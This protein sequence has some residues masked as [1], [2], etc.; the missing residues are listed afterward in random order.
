MKADR[1]KSTQNY[2]MSTVLIAN[3]V[4]HSNG[5]I[6]KNHY[7]LL[8]MFLCSTNNYRLKTKNEAMN[9][10]KQVVVITQ[11]KEIKRGGGLPCISHRQELD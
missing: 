9:Q 6:Q 8:P 5:P 10:H 2:A 7:R 4:P 3:S 11:E 1:T